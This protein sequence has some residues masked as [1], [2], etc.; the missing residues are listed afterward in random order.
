MNDT[1][2]GHQNHKPPMLCLMP[3]QI[4]PRPCSD[5]PAQQADQK[6][7]RFRYSPCMAL[8]PVFIHSH[9]K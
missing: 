4:H 1:N 6:Q 7:I 8:R 9:R 3:K 5:T 2:Q